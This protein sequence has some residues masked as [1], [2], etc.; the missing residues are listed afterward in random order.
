MNAL[1]YA[2]VAAKRLAELPDAATGL[3][4]Q[5]YV[6][7]MAAWSMLSM[8]ESLRDIATELKRVKS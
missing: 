3:D 2:H 6:D 8:A 1:E 4:K 7:D 5:E